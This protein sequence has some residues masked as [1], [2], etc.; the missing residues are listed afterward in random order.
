MVLSA[1][2]LNAA[3][4]LRAT[5]KNLGVYDLPKVVAQNILLQTII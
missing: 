4:E 5:L 2:K 1:V 3:I